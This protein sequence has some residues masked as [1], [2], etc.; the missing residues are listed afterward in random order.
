LKK[1]KNQTDSVKSKNSDRCCYVVNHKR[2]FCE[3]NC[4][5]WLGVRPKIA[6]PLGQGP[7]LTTQ[8]HLPKWHHNASN[9]SSNVTNMTV[10][11]QTYRETDRLRYG[12]MC[13]N[14]RNRLRRKSDSEK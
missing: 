2:S 5:L 1:N 3:S 9:G 10:K 14:M 12:E 7:H 4:A 13:R 8:V 6:L 11:C